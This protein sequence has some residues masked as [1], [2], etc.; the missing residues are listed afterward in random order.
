M[1]FAA[2][3][4]TD[5]STSDDHYV[6]HVRILRLVAQRDDVPVR[7][8]LNGQQF[9]P[10]ATAPAP[11][12]A[13]AMLA[14]P[15]VSAVGPPLG[16]I[17]GGTFLQVSGEHFGGAGTVRRCRFHSPSDSGLVYAEVAATVVAEAPHG[18]ELRCTSPPVDASLIVGAVALSVTAN[19]VE[20]SRPGHPFRYHAPL[21]LTRIEP[22]FGSLDGGTT[23]H[24]AGA[25]SLAALPGAHP[26]AALSLAATRCPSRRPL[27]AAAAAAAAAAAGCAA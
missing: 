21:N 11:P 27:L 19:G 12:L 7:V 4:T 16:S 26:I 25:A 3:T 23:V 20:Y 18:D 2:Q 1:A 9:D 13:L 6:H 8:S 14:R 24:I 10:P 22:A 17:E 15:V 5:P